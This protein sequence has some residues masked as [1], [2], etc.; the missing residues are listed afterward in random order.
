MVSQ[1]TVWHTSKI[2]KELY[3]VVVVVR[4]GSMVVTSKNNNVYEGLTTGTKAWT[5]M[6]VR[7]DVSFH[8]DNFD[9]HLVLWRDE[10]YKFTEN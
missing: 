9:F 5:V 7:I 3:K 8:E 1:I 10:C 4:L 2:G 6:L